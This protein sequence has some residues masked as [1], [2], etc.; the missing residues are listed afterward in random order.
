MTRED[1]ARCDQILEKA[2]FNGKS[3][4]WE[5]LG[6]EAQCGVSART[7]QRE[8]H[9]LDW[10]KCIACR[11]GWV[12]PKH[13]ERRVNWAKEAL[14]LRPNPEDWDNVRFSDEMHAGFGSQGRIWVIRK[15]GTRYCAG[16]IQ[17]TSPEPKDERDSK[18]KHVW[19]AV[20]YGF[21]SPLVFYYVPGNSNG[22][23]TLEVYRDQILEPIVK[24]WINDVISGRS[25]PFTL[26]EDGDSG[27]GTGK[28]NIVR[29][30]KVN[31]MLDC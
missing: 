11:K 9:Q 12:S 23:M 16:C 15:P 19:A 3:L 14:F 4:T 27:H 2:G 31:H 21:K 8:M 26:E 24:P 18:R 30:W 20:G 5:M 22:K 1:V 17:H 7:L 13:A 28:K 25:G 29:T 10:W 6:Y